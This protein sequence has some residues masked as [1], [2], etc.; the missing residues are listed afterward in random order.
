MV[1]LLNFQGMEN[2]QS[3]ELFSA[4]YYLHK[5]LVYLN[6]DMFTAA[7]FFFCKILNMCES[8]A[9]FD[10]LWWA[11]PPRL[12][13]YRSGP[14]C[15]LSWLGM[16]NAGWLGSI[17]SEIFLQMKFIIFQGHTTKQAAFLP[18]QSI[19]Y[20]QLHSQPIL[21]VPEGYFA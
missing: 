2:C 9:T 20:T 3:I 10:L 16:M 13:F 6:F 7:M 14:A 4:Y 5:W 18:R 1:W 19:P 17:R 12:A 8:R 15:L 21:L 11:S